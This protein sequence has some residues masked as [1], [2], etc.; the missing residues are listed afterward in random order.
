[1]NVKEI[2]AMVDKA[3]ERLE[4]A[5]KLLEINN[6]SD[7]ISRSYYAVLDITRA[8]LLTDGVI[9]RSHAGTI[10]K[11]HLLYVKTGKVKIDYGKILTDIEKSR[12]EADY[13]FLIKFTKNDAQGKLLKAKKFVKSVESLLEKNN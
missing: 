8:L 4:S 6:Y 13:D 3:Y 10:T 9:P 11:F 7:S 12:S 2:Q 5:Q 1:M